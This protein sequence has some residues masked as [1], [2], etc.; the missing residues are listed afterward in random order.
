MN[1]DRTSRP[2]PRRRAR[3][4]AAARR[5]AFTLVELLV[6][7]GIIALL[8]AILMPA[9]SAAKR[10]AQTLRCAANLSD[11]GRAMQQY[12]ND[13]RGRIPRGYDY[14]AVYQSGHILWA[15]AISR[16]L[17]HPVEVRDL[18]NARDAV[19]AKEFAQIAVYQ[20]P[21]FPNERQVLDYVSNSWDGG[22]GGGTDGAAIIVTRV[23]RSSEV[24]F[25]TEANAKADVNYFNLHDVWA[26]EHLPT[27]ALP[28]VLND[29]RHGGRLNLLLLDGHVTT[30]T[31]KEVRRADF[32]FLYAGPR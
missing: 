9:L 32:D 10:Q 23:R 25:L 28:R 31:Y 27:G 5:A 19:M 1:V 24:V 13:H 7:I 20:C 29:T 4:R 3:A 16:Y 6:V 15:E 22:T 14:F 26:P 2:R 12:A 18:S 21:V 8:I 11:I 30:K 17:N